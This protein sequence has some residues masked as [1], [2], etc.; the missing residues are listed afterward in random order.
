VA[1]SILLGAL[2]AQMEM[3]PED[4][5][6]VIEARV[7]QKHVEVNRQAFFAGRERDWII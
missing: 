3:P 7:P 5:L 1:N 2:S 4:W 6:A